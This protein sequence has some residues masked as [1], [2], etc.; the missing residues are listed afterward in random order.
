M[1]APCAGYWPSRSLRAVQPRVWRGRAGKPA[2]PRTWPRYVAHSIGVGCVKLE[3]TE[4]GLPVWN[5]VL[6][7]SQISTTWAA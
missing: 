5:E 1:L 7:A 2:R 4:T 3:V 6:I